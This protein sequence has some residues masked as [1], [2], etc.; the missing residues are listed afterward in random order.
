M[1]SLSKCLVFLCIAAFAFVVNADCESDMADDTIM[2]KVEEFK[3]DVS[4]GNDGLKVKCEDFGGFDYFTASYHFICDSGRYTDVN[5][6]AQCYPLSCTADGAVYV[7]A[8]IEGDKYVGSGRD[9]CN[10]HEVTFADI[11]SLEPTPVPTTAAT[12]VPT[13]APT[14]VPTTA[15]TPD[16]TTAP[17]PEPTTAPTP[18]PTIAP[19]TAP[20]TGSIRSSLIFC[21]SLLLLWYFVVVRNA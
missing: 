19:T 12:P 21:G 9:R 20:R 4:A 13:T 18:E 8:L 10:G 2:A 14:P 11:G 1:I 16:A 7:K 6:E 3:A 17:T 5:D 15:P